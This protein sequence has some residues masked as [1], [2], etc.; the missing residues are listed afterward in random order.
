MPQINE[1]QVGATGY[2]LMGF[3]WRPDPT[4]H[5]QAFEAMRA[6]LDNGMNF[7]NGGEFYGTPECNSMT[8]LEAYFAQYPED[9]DKVVLSIK[10][11]FGPHGP[12]GSPEGTRRSIDNVIKQLNGRKKL[13]IF[14]C[15]RRDPS[16]P[17]EDTFRTMQEYIDKGL[18]GGISLS[19]VAASTIHEAVK[20]AKIV[21]VEVELSIFSP[22]VL[23]NGVAAACAEYGIP[24]VAY[25]PIGRGIL[26]GSLKSQSDL[27]PALRIFPRFSPENFSNNLNL[28]TH[29]NALAQKKGCTPAQL[30]L[31]W[32]RCLSRRPGMPTIIPI[33]GSTKA[34]RVQE[35]AVEVELTDAEMDEIDGILARFEVKG[36][37]YPGHITMNT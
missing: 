2:G 34:S 32:T 11:G 25:S 18:L 35:N 27:S 17:M 10:G 5:E 13:D 21:A 37:R 23:T 22:E 15:A 36:E 30:A 9:A 3:T 1:Q 14:E 6:A 33:P 19:E 29:V 16:V 4:P 31:A 24:L 28:F 20:H 8:L 12:D 7:W 26:G